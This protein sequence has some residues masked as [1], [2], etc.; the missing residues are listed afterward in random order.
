MNLKRNISHLTT[1]YI[2]DRILTIVDER[3]FPNRPWLTADAVNILS[4]M[5]GASDIGVEFGSGRSTVWFAQRLGRL[6]SVEH[7]KLWFDKVGSELSRVHLLSKVD[8]HF[9]PDE[10]SYLRPLHEL[11]DCSVDFC[12]VDGELRED[13]ALVAI[14][15][16]KPGSLLVID[17]VNWYLPND[18]TRSPNS[19][20]TKTGCASDKWTRFTEITGEWRFIWTTNGVTDTGIWFKPC[21]KYSDL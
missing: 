11:P 2:F 9:A 18:K 10:A 15:K 5:I 8:Y 4:T 14:E 13:C 21:G 17:N 12:L 6:I 3:R 16:L 1:R 20:R 19:R 7:D